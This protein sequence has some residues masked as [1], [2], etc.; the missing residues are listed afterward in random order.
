MEQHFEYGE[1]E[2]IFDKIKSA[3]APFLNDFK[4]IGKSV[5]SRTR[6]MHRPTTA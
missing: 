6:N 1:P 3:V 5:I 4:E 2:T